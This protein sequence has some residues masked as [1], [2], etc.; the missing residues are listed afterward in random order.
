MRGRIN[1]LSSQLKIKNKLIIGIVGITDHL[2]FAEM[3]NVWI[4]RAKKVLTAISKGRFPDATNVIRY[5]LREQ[6]RK[7][8]SKIYLGIWHIGFRMKSIYDL[9]AE[10][11]LNLADHA[12]SSNFKM[13]T[14][15][16]AAAGGYCI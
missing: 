7:I 14:N 10:N 4:S 15:F 12:L 11:W 8:T 3:Q 16:M 2:V 5:P 13:Y 9:S 1:I 6:Y